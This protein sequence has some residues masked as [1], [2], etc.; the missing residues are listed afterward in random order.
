[1][2]RD[3]E[4]IDEQEHLETIFPHL[5][6]MTRIAVDTEAD[7]L[8]HYFEKVCLI[9]ISAGGRHFIVDPLA[10]LD[11]AGLMDIFSRH[12]LIFHGADYDLRMLRMSFDFEPQAEVFDTML[13]GQ[14][15]GFE[16]FG[17]AALVQHYFDVELPKGGQKWDW[18]RRPLPEKYLSYAA[19]DT[20]YLEELAARMEA[21]LLE[22]G[23]REWHREWCREVVEASASN[24]EPDPEREWRIKGYA[25]LDRKDMA[26]LRELWYWR[27][28]ESRSADLPPFKILNNSQ[29]LGI[30]Q[31]LSENPQEPPANCPD[32]PKNC[33]GRRLRDINEAVKK[34]RSLPKSEWPPARIKGGKYPTRSKED[35]A[36]MHRMKQKRDELAKDL[37]LP[38][39]LLANK[40]A[41][42]SISAQRPITEEAMIK[43]GN[44]MRWQGKLLAEH[45]LSLLQD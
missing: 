2:P 42:M 30:V 4:Y 27:D 8:H 9:Q 43:S 29:L 24:K 1:M 45:W 16:Q 7:S 28:G 21:D 23:R 37:E 33:R 36:L 13:A 6:G 41:L 22:K 18:S 25:N 44:L 12:E 19:D 3:F 17:L 34:G 14:L 39:P 31:W 32:L 38:P 10:K 35:E 15:L 11:L 20:R 26:L 5:E 40:A